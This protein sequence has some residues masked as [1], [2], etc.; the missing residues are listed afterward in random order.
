MN[1]NR[2][3]ISVSQIKIMSAKHI[4]EQA[5]IEAVSVNKMDSAHAGLFGDIHLYV[6]KD[7]SEEA[8]QLLTDEG[9]L[10]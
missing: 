10:D 9:I 7:R 1:E 5:G 8:I 2:I 3:L 6:P 4:L